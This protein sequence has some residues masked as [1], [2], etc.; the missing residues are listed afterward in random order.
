MLAVA[1][2]A[3]IYYGVQS[4]R[5]RKAIENAIPQVIGEVRKQRDELAAAIEAYKKQYGSYPPT[6]G[7]GGKTQPEMN[8]LFYELVGTR[9]DDA[10]ENF[11]DPT[12]KQALRAEDLERIFGVRCFTNTLPF[13]S[14]PTDFLS[15]RQLGRKELVEGTGV[16]G[17]GFNESGVPEEAAVD[18]K[19]SPWRYDA[20][21]PRHNIN[22]FDLWIE[23]DV[24]GQHYTIG[25][26]PEAR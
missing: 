14:W 15:P 9:H 3:A 10:K 21:Q 11:F 17:V 23:V 7:V 19:F 20:L 8:S 12:Q 4:V 24:P 2:G 6:V 1:L 16:F 5:H 22:R 26:W 25:N 18:F 13:P